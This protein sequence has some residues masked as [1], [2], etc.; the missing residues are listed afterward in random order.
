MDWD[1]S[2]TLWAQLLLFLTVVVGF[3]YIAFSASR[4]R[5]WEEEDRKL[6]MKLL[7]KLGA[8]E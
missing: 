7:R 6:L 3:S 2:A 5:R 4:M 8:D 1:T